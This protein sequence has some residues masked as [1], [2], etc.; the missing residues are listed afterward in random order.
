MRTLHL[1]L[2]LLRNASL[3]S[4]VT[5]LLIRCG[6]LLLSTLL[7]L[8]LLLGICT[9]LVHVTDVAGTFAGTLS[10]YS[11]GESICKLQP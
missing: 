11:V 2:E 7:L 6:L 3:R 10:M 4:V 9:L 8:Q 5:L 1:E